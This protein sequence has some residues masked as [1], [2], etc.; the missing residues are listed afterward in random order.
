MTNQYNQQAGGLIFTNQGN[1]VA[2]LSHRQAMNPALVQAAI[3]Q[4]T[5]QGLQNM[6]P[7]PHPKMYINYAAERMQDLM[8]E[9]AKSRRRHARFMT[10]VKVYWVVWIALQALIWLPKLL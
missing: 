4:L 5:Q 6:M 3:N 10:C 7:P 2:N 9:V 1:V 8:N